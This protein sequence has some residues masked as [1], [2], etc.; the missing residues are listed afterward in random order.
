[1]SKRTH[2]VKPGESLW[3]IAKAYYGNG[4]LATLIFN[5]NSMTI[6]D[7]NRVYPGQIIVIPHVPGM[8]WK[9]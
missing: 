5:V 8:D 3:D 4:E 6:Y 7:I 1:M 9:C 2:V